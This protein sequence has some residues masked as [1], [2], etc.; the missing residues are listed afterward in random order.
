MSNELI[1]YFSN[2]NKCNFINQKIKHKLNTNILIFFFEI[3][4]CFGCI[5]FFILGNRFDDTVSSYSEIDDELLKKFGY[6]K[7]DN[8]LSLVSECTKIK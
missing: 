1:W 5:T 2:S 8:N 7:D 6:K 3:Y 4:I